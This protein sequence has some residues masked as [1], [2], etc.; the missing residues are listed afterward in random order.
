MKTNGTN[1]TMAHECIVGGYGVKP[2]A[3]LSAYVSTFIGDNIAISIL[4]YDLIQKCAVQKG[5]KKLVFARKGVLLQC[6]PGRKS[7]WETFFRV[8]GICMCCIPLRCHV[9]T[10]NIYSSLYENKEIASS[11]SQWRATRSRSTACTLFSFYLSLYFPLQ[12]NIY[13]ANFI[14]KG[15]LEMYRPIFF[16]KTVDNLS[17]AW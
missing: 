10:R 5:T 15:N 7:L 16:F 9:C 8:H 3:T 14:F 1:D 6:A 2:F 12:L 11:D 13:N 17:D 4:F